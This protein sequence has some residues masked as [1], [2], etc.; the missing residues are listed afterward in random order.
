MTAL[1]LPLV[2]VLL[3]FLLLQAVPGSFSTVGAQGQGASPSGGTF[4]PT[5]WVHLPVVFGGGGPAITLTEQV[6]GL[7]TPTHVTHA[8]DG[9]GRLFVT[10]KAGRIRVVRGGTLLATPFLSITGR[11]RSAGGEQGLLSVAF[12]PGYEGKGYFYVD[13]TDTD[14][15]TV[16]ARYHLTGDPDLANPDSEE[17]I[18]TQTQPFGNHNG[19]Q[20]AFG[21]DGYLYIGMGDGGG[22]GDPQ[23]NA[24]DPTSLLGKLLR[25]DVES[26]AT[27]YSIPPSNPY[28]ETAGYEDEIWALG[29]R[30]PWRFSFDRL[31]GDLY[32]GD[33]GQ[34]DYE[35]ID[36]QPASSAGG[37]N[38]GWNIMEGMRCY[39]SATCDQTGL[40][41]PVVAY[42]HSV[43]CSVTGG[44]VYRG[45]GNPSMEGIYFYGDYCSGRIWG[46]F[47]EGGAWRE[48]LLADTDVTITSFG[49]DEAGNLYV[50][51]FWGGV[52]Y[53]VTEAP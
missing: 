9:S 51:D 37:E 50:A 35:E 11:V 44:I 10:E 27:P 14:G 24:Q 53:Q 20:L 2:I 40:T 42:D 13:Y 33:V 29:L 36:F 25:I 41:L 3:L 8:G 45:R 7:E 1:A 46:L 21:P 16:V 4:T 18:L 6:D 47:R 48:S 28:T 19:G 34:N 22:G 17:I 39:S 30:N 15:D 43:G 23:G 26:G 38:Y 12:P 52:I 49:E 31:T 5:D 32:I